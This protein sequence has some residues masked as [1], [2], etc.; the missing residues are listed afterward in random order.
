[1]KITKDESRILTDALQEAKYELAVGNRP[2]FDKLQILEAK[3]VA[4][5]KDYRRTGRT[6]Q[7]DDCDLYKRFIKNYK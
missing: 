1:M 4:N 5:A 7:D 3:L 6:S 2:L